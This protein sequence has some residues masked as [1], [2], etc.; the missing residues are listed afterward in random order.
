[1]S[2]VEAKIDLRSEHWKIVRDLLYMHVPE[3]RVLAFGSRTSGTARKYSD[4]DLALVGEEPL[5]LE[6]FSALSEG[7][8]DSDLPFK[9]DLVDWAQVDDKLRAAIRQSGVVVQDPSNL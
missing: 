4:L 2:E 3:R 8:G 9:V 6:V 5:S 7:F 1:M